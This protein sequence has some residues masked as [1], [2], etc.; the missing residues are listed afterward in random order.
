MAA[1]VD[2]F[3]GYRPLLFAVAYRMVGVV[4]DAEDLVQETFLRW[5]RALAAGETIAAPKSW[6][7]AVIT[8]LCID[9]LRSARVRREE[10]VGPWLPEPLVTEA[11]PDP[12]ES[13]ALAESLTLAFL[14]VIESLTPVERAVFLLHDVFA[15]D[16]AEVARI[17][18]KGEANCRQLARRAREHVAARRPRH[19]APPE[20]RERLTAQFLAA[21]QGGDLP[22]L[23]ATLADEI[24][25]RS[26]GGGKAQ[27]ARRPLHGPDAVA[28]FLL[29][30]IKKAPAGTEYRFAEVNGQPG[31][32]A[33][34]DGVPYSVLA[35]DI[36]EGRVRSIAIVVNPD[37]LG[38]V[39]ATAATLA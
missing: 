21:C 25:L 35:L 34:L 29:G 13:V 27:A 1:R 38:S 17:V 15:Y 32:L 8:R 36:A 12:A 28:R 33:L 30:I 20:E 3:T 22:T 31:F 2:E 26:D 37:K 39:R 7:T 18:G 9:H 6:L 4:A 14:V 19:Q 23:V 10:Y 11:A 16:F 24:V 5:Q